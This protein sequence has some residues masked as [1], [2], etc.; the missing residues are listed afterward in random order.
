MNSSSFIGIGAAAF[1]LAGCNLIFG[2]QEGRVDGAGGT[3]G[4]GGGPSG[5]TSSTTSGVPCGDVDCNDDN[6]CTDDFCNGSQECW[7][8]PAVSPELADLQVSGDCKRVVCVDAPMPHTEVEA[9]DEDSPPSDG[10]DCTEDLCNGDMPYPK[11]GAGGPCDNFAGVCDG[12]GAC[13]GCVDAGHCPA[14]TQCGSYTCSAANTCDFTGEVAGAQLDDGI[15]G[16]CQAFQCNGSDSTTTSVPQNM[17]VPTT[18]PN[19][20]DCKRPG[21]DDGTP[22]FFDVPVPNN[23]PCDD[24]AVN[25][26][27]GV[28]NDGACDDCNPATD[29]GC[30]MGNVCKTTG[31][32]CTP[33]PSEVF[34]MGECGVAT[35]NC[36]RAF[37]CSCTNSPK[38]TD[39]GAGNLCGCDV[40][41]DCVAAELGDF[42]LAASPRRCGCISPGDCGTNAFGKQCFTASNVC[43]CQNTTDCVGIARGP[44]CKGDQRCGCTV[45]ADCPAAAP[46]CHQV[47]GCVGCLSSADCAT[48]NCDPVL[49]ACVP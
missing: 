6:R 49:H 44:V 37:M 3:G 10:N 23:D 46:V 35:D 1:A 21:C 7:H 48:L 30:L 9:D 12:F 43:G 13:V 41:A 5:P 17:D 31:G 18:D 39:C 34:C 2:I 36:N 42:C 29:A 25:E 15:T 38:G 24:G 22:T 27:A 26:D 16:N 32:C 20:T 45:N 40:D 28:C 19:S 4:G 33:N 11:K 8:A 47:I 14:A